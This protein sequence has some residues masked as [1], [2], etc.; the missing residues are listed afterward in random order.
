MKLIYFLFFI[1]L[2]SNVYGFG[3]SPSEFNINLENGQELERQFFIFNDNQI[4]LFNIS[5]YEISFFNFSSFI[6]EIDENNQKEIKFL[7]NVPFETENGSYSGRIYVKEDR[8]SEGGINI[9]TLLGI[10]VNI[11]VKSNYSLDNDEGNLKEDLLLKQ[12]DNDE[13]T[14]SEEINKEDLNYL[15]YFKDNPELI[16]FCGLII[17]VLMLCL[18]RILIKFIFKE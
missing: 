9:D 5:S 14:F 15:V 7:I 2:I 1:F 4:K 12:E 16:L 10:K 18:C 6:V 8:I 3:V 13:I 11:N 17:L